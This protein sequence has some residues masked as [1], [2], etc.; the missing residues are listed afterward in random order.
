VTLEPLSERV[1]ASWI[2]ADIIWASLFVY[3][4][5]RAKT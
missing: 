4:Q 5:Q 3:V 2:A 1:V